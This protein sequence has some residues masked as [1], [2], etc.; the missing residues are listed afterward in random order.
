MQNAKKPTRLAATSVP[1]LCDL[2]PGEFPIPSCHP[3]RHVREKR[4]TSLKKK[5]RE[6]KSTKIGQKKIKFVSPR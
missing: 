4:S 3:L 5:D 2:F 1:K 6:K